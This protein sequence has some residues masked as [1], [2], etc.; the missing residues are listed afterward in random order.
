MITDL[1]GVLRK[2][3]SVDQG[4]VDAMM[5]WAMATLCFFVFFRSVELTVLRTG[6][7]MQ[8][9]MLAERT[10]SRTEQ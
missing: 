10:Y 9:C 4:G 7:S 3:W 1:L 2:S 5:L 8:G 6:S